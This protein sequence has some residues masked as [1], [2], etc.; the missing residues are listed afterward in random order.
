M[1]CLN[2]QEERNTA[3]GQYRRPVVVTLLHKLHGRIEEY[4]VVLDWIAFQL[5]WVVIDP[6]CH[7]TYRRPCCPCSVSCVRVSSLYVC[8]HVSLSQADMG[9]ERQQAVEVLT[10][11]HAQ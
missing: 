5:L 11:E 2:A 4:D 3:G 8:M 6:P 7:S 9:A 1:Y 10:Q